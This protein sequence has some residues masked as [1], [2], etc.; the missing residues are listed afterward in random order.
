MVRTILF[1]NKN[2]LTLSAAATATAVAASIFFITG[3]FSVFDTSL[4]WLIEYQDIFKFAL[5]VASIIAASLIFFGVFSD[6]MKI[7]QSEGK[8]KKIG[9]I[10]VVLGIMVYCLYPAYQ[11]YKSGLIF[12]LLYELS[13]MSTLLLVF[14][15]LLIAVDYWKQ[16]SN[17]GRPTAVQNMVIL[18]FVFASISLM[19]VAYGFRTKADESNRKDLITKDKSNTEMT[20]SKIRIVIFLSH[21][22][23]FEH[24]N[25]IYIIPTGDIVRISSSSPN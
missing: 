17:G 14:I 6:A 8:S 20:Y 1:I 22:F 10:A 11:F 24:E 19:G 5:I 16:I 3:Y 13:F 18:V 9:V 21:H 25:R 23:V 12:K 4:I 15:I 2:F 7:A